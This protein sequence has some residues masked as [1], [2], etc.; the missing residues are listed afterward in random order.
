MRSA[1][2][3]IWRIRSRVTL[4]SLPTSSKVLGLPSS[5]PKRR[6]STF[7]SLGVRVLS[8]SASCSLSRLIEAASAGA[9]A[10]SSGIKSPK[11]LSS[12]SPM[13]VSKDT[14]SWATRIISRTLSTGISKYSEIS[15]AVGSRPFWCSSWLLAFFTLLMVSTMC[16]GIRMVRA[17]SAI[18]RVMAWRI[19]Q[20]A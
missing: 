7:S 14:G 13:G 8:T 9:S 4:N 20:V 3:S 1:L 2:A 17:W 18:A 12:S 6:L 19:H 15:S 16:T 11:W 10:S 5:K